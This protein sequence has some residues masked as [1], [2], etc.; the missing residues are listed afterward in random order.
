MLEQPYILYLY[1]NMNTTQVKL[2][3]ICLIYI[4]DIQKIKVVVPCI[5]IY[6]KIDY[7]SQ[8][9]CLIFVLLFIKKKRPEKYLF[10]R[11]TPY[12][13]P[14]Y[15]LWAVYNIYLNFQ[16]IIFSFIYS[17][18]DKPN[19]TSIYFNRYKVQESNTHTVLYP[20]V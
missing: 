20:F 16:V 10:R 3:A 2:L 12:C 11:M 4:R 13:Q 15:W 9:R 6:S 7:F 8:W 19:L 17:M 5:N 1:L 14:S 18:A